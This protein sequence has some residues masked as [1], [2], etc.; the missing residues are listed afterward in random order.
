MVVGVDDRALDREPDTPVVP[1]QQVH[2]VPASPP[3]G[4]NVAYQTNRTSSVSVSVATS[5]YVLP[6]ISVGVNTE[7]VSIPGDLTEPNEPI[8][9]DLVTPS[10]PSGSYEL[11]WDE[12]DT[13]GDADNLKNAGFCSSS[14]DGN[15]L[16]SEGHTEED[17]SF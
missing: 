12:G 4:I 11:D 7:S 13:D 14:K 1:D 10:E 16:P 15:A 2:R 17:K 3:P 9:A 5:D 8:P 6:P